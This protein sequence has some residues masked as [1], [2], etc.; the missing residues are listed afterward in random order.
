VQILFLTGRERENKSRL[1]T[2]KMIV[3]AKDGSILSNIKDQAQSRTE[4]L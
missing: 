2:L 1:A 4:E 3:M